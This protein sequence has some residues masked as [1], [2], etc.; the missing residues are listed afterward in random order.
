MECLQCHQKFCP[1]VTLKSI[2]SFRPLIVSQQCQLCRSQF[3]EI[4]NGGCLICSKETTKDC[5]ADCLAWQ[6]KYPNSTFKLEPIFKYSEEMKEWIALYKFKGHRALCYC[7]AEE[8]ANYFSNQHGAVVIPIPLASSRYQKR[9]FN[10]VEELLKAGSVTYKKLLN[11]PAQTM[12]QNK[13]SK[14]ERLQTSQPF[15][16]NLGAIACIRGRDIILVDDIYTTGR[17]MYWAVELIEQ[18]SP[19]T[20]KGFCLAR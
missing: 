19:K 5:C 8:I 4:S 12:E 17:T 16:L 10:Q 11:K 6:A 7:F 20:I 14:V 3:E 13:K 18:C 1:H 2:F 15:Q 9:G